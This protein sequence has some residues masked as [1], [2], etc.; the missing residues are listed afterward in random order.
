APSVALE[1]GATYTATITLGARNLANESLAA[2]EVW[3]FD[4]IATAGAGPAPVILGRAGNYALF[5]H[6]GIT[7][8]V[9]ALT[10]ITGNIAVS[11]AAAS[12]I[13]NMA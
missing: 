13:T 7:N 10:T 6:E 11:P 5:A 9:Q 3:T 12:T 1:P 4:T 2:A 8:T